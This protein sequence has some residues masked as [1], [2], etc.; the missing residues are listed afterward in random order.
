MK[1]TNYYKRALSVVSLLLALVLLFAAC[2]EGGTGDTGDAETTEPVETSD[3]TYT[4]TVNDANGAPLKNIIVEVFKG[5]ASC[6]INPT[7]E[8]GTATF[9]L[10]A[11]DYTFTLTAVGG[12]EG[13]TY[14]E[15]LCVLSAQTRDVTVMMSK[16]ASSAPTETL[17]VGSGEYLAAHVG[18]GSTTVTLTA[19]D[20]TYFLFAP[21]R[22]GMFKFSAESSEAETDIGYYGGTFFVQSSKAAEMIDDYFLINVRATNI[23]VVFVIG[24]K[25]VDGSAADAMLKIERIG[26]AE[27]DSADAPWTAVQADAQYLKSYEGSTGGTLKDVDITSK[28]TIVKGSDGY[29]H[30][31]TETGPVVM[32]RIDSASPYVASFVEICET[33]PLAAY[34][35][36]EDGKFVKKEH[37]N[38][39]ISAYLEY[40]DGNGTVPLN[41]QLISMVKNVGEHMGWWNEDRA[42]YLFSEDAEGK[43]INEDKDSAW[44]FACC[45]YE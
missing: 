25:T 9:T 37:Y 5:T 33:S 21:T 14:D 35:Y 3:V 8:S 2:G 23:G 24:I 32:L 38:E 26:D 27:T 19:N 28:V 20:M 15:S 13:Y 45:Y 18:E 39:L 7:N 30:L 36:D 42:N 12:D 31:G 6:G 34:Y 29:Y 40:V 43:P 1:S 17:Y 4:V 16:T 22:A 44:M 41:D 10:A 11:G